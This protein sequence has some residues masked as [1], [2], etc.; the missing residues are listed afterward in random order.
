M[1]NLRA[2]TFVVAILLVCGALPGAGQTPT[3]RKTI[4]VDAKTPSDAAGANGHGVSG[5]R[6]IDVSV[7]ARLQQVDGDPKQEGALVLGVQSEFRDG[8]PHRQPSLDLSPRL[9]IELPLSSSGDAYGESRR[10]YVSREGA[11]TF[12]FTAGL[13]EKNFMQFAPSEEREFQF[14]LNKYLCR[15]MA[16]PFQCPTVFGGPTTAVKLPSDMS[17]WVVGGYR[18]VELSSKAAQATAEISPI[19]L[20]SDGK[21]FDYGTCARI[22]PSNGL[23]C[24][25][26]KTTEWHC[27]GKPEGEGWDQVSG[28]CWH[29][30]T[31]GSCSE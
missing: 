13:D 10:C 22:A 12:V 26:H 4:R 28:D 25:Q 23:C 9:I 30:E 31:G 6:A 29:R 18:S 1:A 7:R 17:K 5:D 19:V 15:A 2:S 11:L 3:T 8:K 27:G 14:S 21:P 24:V 16:A 20:Q